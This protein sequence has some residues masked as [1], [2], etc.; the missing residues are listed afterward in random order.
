MRY[1]K[2]TEGGYIVTIGTGGSGA[3]E[4]TSEEYN[5][6]MA[7]IRERPTPPDGYGYLLR[8]DLMW[9]LYE[10]PPEE[11]NPDPELN[12]TEAIAIMLGDA[13]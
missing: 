6:I 4:I 13:E 11:V 10:L 1:W 8:E 2:V 9:E 5:E 3:G 12:D 7:A